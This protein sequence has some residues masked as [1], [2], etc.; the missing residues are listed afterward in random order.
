MTLFEI[1]TRIF[2]RLITTPNPGQVQRG[3]EGD[4]RVGPDAGQLISG[5]L[6]CQLD[7]DYRADWPNGGRQPIRARCNW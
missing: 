2:C 6:H 1:S 5:Q 7:N 3:I 4:R